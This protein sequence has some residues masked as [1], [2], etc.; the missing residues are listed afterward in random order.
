MK[1][2][3]YL[4]IAVRLFAI[5]IF[6]FGLRQSTMLV[7]VLMRGSINDMNVSTLF[8]LATTL[9]PL[10]S[11]VFLWHFPFSVTNSILRPEID[12]PVEPMN[13][14]SMLTVLVLAIGLIALYN[15]LIDSMFWLTLWHMSEQ[16]MYSDVQLSIN[17]EN[18][19][20][21]VST[22]LELGLSIIIILKAKSLSCRMLR[23]TE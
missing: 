21:M 8:M 14:Q 5:A 15:A 1:S 4:A 22:A 16:S 11:S 7:Q 12:L 13:A 6:I 3:H 19:A 2:S 10:I 18:K 17:N 23:L 20:N 9:F